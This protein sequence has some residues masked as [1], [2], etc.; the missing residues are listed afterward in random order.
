M[1]NLR[2]CLWIAVLTLPLCCRGQNDGGKGPA[3][4]AVVR[5][6][7]AGRAALAQGS[8]ATRLK[9]V[10]ALPST[11]SLR[12]QIATSLSGAP[13]KLWNNDLPAGTPNGASLLLPIFEDLLQAESY[14]EVRGTFG[15]TETVLAIE[16]SEE[17][18]RLW[19]SNLSQLAAAWKQGT[20][21]PLTRDGA[22]GWELK[23]GQAPNLF[24]LVRAGKWTVLALGQDRLTLA[25]AFLQQIKATGRPA[26]ATAAELVDLDANSPALSKWFSLFSDLDLPPFKLTISGRG[27]HVRTEVRLRYPAPLVL[28]H[29]AWRIPTNIISEPLSSFTVA[30]SAAQLVNRLLNFQSLGIGAAPNQFC[31]WGITNDPCR[32]YFTFPIADA[33]G[34]M[35]KMAVTIPPFIENT[36]G[37]YN[38]DFLYASNRNTLHWTLPYIQPYLQTMASGGM[39]FVHGGIFPLAPR[40]YP[41]PPEL[42]AQIGTRT[43]L[44]YYDWEMTP[45]RISHSEQ[46]Y[47]ILNLASHRSL[48][49]AGTAS[50]LWL[51]DMVRELSKDTMNPSQTVTEVSQTGPN[52]MTL[53]RKSHLGLTGFEIATL[54]AWLDSP[55][56]P[57]RYEPPHRF[58]SAGTNAPAG[59]TNRPGSQKR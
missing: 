21:A 26:P 30:R 41:V 18:A 32:V 6:H 16:L 45:F 24:Q 33:A 8:N 52:E 59:A 56:F 7:F 43:N 36:L 58:R 10:D 54:S 39:Q 27:E 3:S 20:P 25:P 53:T 15:R 42:F 31:F 11:A 28:K 19:A 34:A 44:V 12:S 4:D 14:G 2:M 17:R 23:R 1:K 35:K 5:W 51:K 47:Q 50:K 48:Q 37:Q 55:G 13:R 22:T 57:F 9:L 40:N 38:G 49:S 29:E 46:L